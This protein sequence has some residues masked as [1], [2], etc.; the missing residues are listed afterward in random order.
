REGELRQLRKQT[1]ELEE[2]NA[3]LSKHIENMKQ[4][5]DKLQVEAIQQRNNNMALQGHLDAL[6]Q[7]LTANFNNIPLPGSNEIPTL[8]TIDT[9]MA[10]L[11]SVILEQP[12][13]NEKLIAQVR[14]IVGRLNIDSTS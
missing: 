8:E 13:K 3:I 1:T 9:Y 7:T 4:A 11:H 14:D 5:I 2:Q 6:R 12:Q 10:R